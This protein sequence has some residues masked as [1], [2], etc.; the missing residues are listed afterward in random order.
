MRPE[1]QRSPSISAGPA[2]VLAVVAVGT[3]LSA[4]AGSMVNLALPSLGRD[5]GISIETSR[6]VVQAFLLTVAVLLLPAGRISDILG[7]GRMYLFGFALFGAMSVLCGAAD[8]FWVLIAGRVFQGV[9]GA[10]AMAAGPALLTTAFPA[11]QRGRVLGLMATSTYVGLMAGPSVAGA[12]VEWLSWRFVFHFMAPISLVVIVAGAPFLPRGLPPPAVRPGGTGAAMR[13]LLGLDLF[14][15]RLFLGA[16]L[17]ALCNYASLFAMILLV[18]FYLEEGLGLESATA[19]LLLTAQPLM[20]A[21]TAAPAGWISDRIGSQ[22]L[23]TAGMGLLAASLW[24]LSTLGPESGICCV[25]AWLGACG[26]STGLFVSPNSSALMGSAPLENQGTAGSL[27]AE[28]RVLGMLIGVTMASTVFH[29]WGG[30]TGA[31]W[32]ATEFDALS[33]VLRISAGVALAGAVL[34]FLRGPRP[35]LA[36]PGV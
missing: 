18:P 32:T 11:H 1:S 35:G 26:L 12:I 6:W 19:G 31:E 2:V 27:L 5:L 36:T 34:A 14:R 17:S 25:A 24:G 9:G 8:R 29:A 4:M 10:L 23:A 21:L 20:M 28:A 33:L 13:R 16:A 15:S 22:G 30:R 3:L 7:H